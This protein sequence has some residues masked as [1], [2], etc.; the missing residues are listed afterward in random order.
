LIGLIFLLSNSNK[1]FHSEGC[2]FTN[3]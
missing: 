3:T 1:S 2:N